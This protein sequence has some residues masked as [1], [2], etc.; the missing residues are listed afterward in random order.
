MDVLNE[1]NSMVMCGVRVELGSRY[2]TDKTVP[3]VFSVADRPNV[4]VVS[5]KKKKKRMLYVL[6]VR[7]CVCVC[8]REFMLFMQHAICF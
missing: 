1:N 5:K 6:C 4:V 8:S 7:A 2:S 3:S